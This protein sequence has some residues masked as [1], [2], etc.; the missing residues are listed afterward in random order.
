MKTPR[1]VNAVGFIDDELIAGAAQ[2]ANVKKSLR[3]KWSVM[4]A[5][6]CLMTAVALMAPMMVKNWGFFDTGEDQYGNTVS[7]V[8]WSDDKTIRDGA[9]NS[10]LL[11]N[12]TNE[13][14]PIFK[15][16]TLKDLEEF[17]MKYES[18]LSM[19][20]GYDNVLSFEGV[21]NKSQW[22]NEDF[23]DDSSLLIIYVPAGSGS[24][25]FGVRDV[26]AVG[27]SICVC[28]EQKNDPEIVTADMVGWLI[29]VEL[30]D[31]EIKGYTSFDAVFKAK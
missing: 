30:D 15:L 26:V 11:Q 8:G 4:A 10:E 17:K 27:D 16:D 7:Y 9:L 13:H 6:L 31:E 1:I 5:C 23:Y 2:E 22:N 29:L 28:V 18:V 20:Q 25:R 24:L 19:D 3:L 14:L 21:L 12:D